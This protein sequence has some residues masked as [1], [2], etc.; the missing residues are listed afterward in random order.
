MADYIISK[1]IIVGHSDL[2]G[3]RGVFAAED[4]N[5]GDLIER[6]PMVKMA[7]R[8]NYLKDPVIWEYLYTHGCECEN[9][10]NHG[11]LFYMVLGY[12]MIYNHQ[13]SPNADWKF[14]Y[15]EL[16]ADVVANKNIATGEEIF[17]SYGPNYFRDREKI[18][19][20]NIP[21]KE[22][23]KALIDSDSDEQFMA[24]M[25]NILYSNTEHKEDTK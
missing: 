14:N 3:S 4:L 8:S 19:A 24:D 25:K 15:K 9:C 2:I 7:W 10:K 13:D 23:I 21:N 22:Q 1:K 6:C 12:G 11:Y 20:N 16:Y 5:S 18:I 17:V